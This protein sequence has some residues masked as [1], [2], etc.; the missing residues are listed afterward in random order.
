MQSI[1][2]SSGDGGKSQAQRNIVCI[3]AQGFLQVSYVMHP[4][5]EL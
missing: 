2:I 5:P 1:A 4:H 3:V